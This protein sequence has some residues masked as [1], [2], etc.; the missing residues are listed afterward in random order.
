MLMLDEPLGN[1][2]GHYQT[3][4]HCRVCFSETYRYFDMGTIAMSDFLPVDEDPVRAPLLLRKCNKCGLVQLGHTVKRDLLYREYWYRSG[5][6]E[7]MVDDLRD[8]VLCAR[9]FVDVEP[10][11]V[12]VDIGSNDGTLLSHWSPD[13]HRIGFEPAENLAEYVDHGIEMVWDFFSAGKYPVKQKARVITAIAMFYD[14]DRPTEF[15]REC[16]QI[17]AHDGVIVIQQNYLL[18]MLFGSDYGNVCHEHLAYHSLASMRYACASAGLAIV[19][20]DLND[21]NGGSFRLYI[22]HAEHGEG[23]R[24]PF[25]VAAEA[26][27]LSRVEPIFPGRCAAQ[28][29]SLRAIVRGVTDAGGVVDVYGASTKGNTIL[30]YAGIDSDL[31]RCA[32][33]RNPEKFGRVMVGSRIP[34]V[35]EAASKATPPDYYLV[36]PWAFLK[37]FIEREKEWLSNGG[38]FIVPLPEAKIL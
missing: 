23:P 12:V 10:G 3:V 1:N 32:A 15:L 37:H 21:V 33:D 6:N 20:C 16:A 38:K 18:T 4:N 30:Q 9:D 36:L 29:E 17:L 5:V 11:D 8:V 22:K 2:M 26:K 35:S 13:L 25:R 28:A 14:L 19:G 7:Q 34:V 24:I 31:I 27:A